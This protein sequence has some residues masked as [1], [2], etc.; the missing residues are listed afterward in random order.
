MDLSPSRSLTVPLRC[1]SRPRQVVL[2]CLE[3]ASWTVTQYES[4]EAA[5]GVAC[6]GY[7]VLKWHSIVTL[8]SDGV[9]LWFGVGSQRWNLFAEDVK[10]RWCRGRNKEE[11][12][13]A[14]ERGGVEVFR[15]PYPS[16]FSQPAVALDPTYDAMDE[17]GEDF[18]AW[19]NGSLRNERWRE[20]WTTDWAPR[21]W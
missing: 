10:Y 17:E 8:W 3:D 2:F 18:F 7:A 5:N 16:V 13:V 9:A 20:L 15:R 14:I 11:N 19:L 21:A 6:R 12:I 4:A 1:W